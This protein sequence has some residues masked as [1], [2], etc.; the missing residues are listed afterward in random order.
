MSR[1]HSSSVWVWEGRGTARWIED[2]WQER[3]RDV[4]VSSSPLLTC[5]SSFLTV[6][7]P[8]ILSIHKRVYYLNMKINAFGIAF[9]LLFGFSFGLFCLFY[10]R[11]RQHSLF[12][13]LP[14]NDPRPTNATQRL[15]GDNQNDNSPAANPHGA[16]QSGRETGHSDNDQEFDAGRARTP[17]SLEEG[18]SGNDGMDVWVGIAVEYRSH[19]EA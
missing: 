1:R 15:S 4:W 14:D 16:V 6:F 9:P 19:G 2:G 18:R 3:R 7:I 13:W 10:R 8:F 11:L 17:R 12:S 5:F